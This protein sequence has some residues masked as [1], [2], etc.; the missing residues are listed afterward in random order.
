V[1]R[2]RPSRC[3]QATASTSTMRREPPSPRPLERSHT[4]RA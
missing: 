4:P 2:C 3:S 1:A